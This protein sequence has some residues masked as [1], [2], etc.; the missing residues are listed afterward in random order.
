MTSR[1]VWGVLLVAMSTLSSPAAAQTQ[2]TAGPSPAS[3][4]AQSVVLVHGAFAD[5]SSWADVIARLQAVGLAVTAVQI[6]LTSLA[7]DV[8]ATRC[9][10]AAQDGPV[11]LVGHAYGGAVITEAGADPSW[12]GSST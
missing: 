5:A 2:D 1:H 3:G 11:V 10:L 12:R 9:A 8:A 6:P 4:A 7:E